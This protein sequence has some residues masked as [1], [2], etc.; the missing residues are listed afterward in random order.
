MCKEEAG[1]A[2][3]DVQR[4]SL[5]VPSRL[6]ATYLRV[7]V[8]SGHADYITIHRVSVLGSGGSHKK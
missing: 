6:T 4:L 1:D 8:M 2:E 7:K 5:D 3:G